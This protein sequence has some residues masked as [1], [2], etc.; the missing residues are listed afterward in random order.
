MNLEMFGDLE[1]ILYSILLQSLMK[2]CILLK[3]IAY[4]YNYS[5]K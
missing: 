2:F 1:Y 4:S 5:N 3:F